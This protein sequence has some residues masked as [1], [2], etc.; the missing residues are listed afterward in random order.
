MDNLGKAIDVSV[1]ILSE[2]VWYFYVFP[3]FF[4]KVARE[5]DNELYLDLIYD[6][7]QGKRGDIEYDER[8]NK[9]VNAYSKEVEL[10][11][12]K[13]DIIFNLVDEKD[14]LAFFQEMMSLKNLNEFRALSIKKVL[15][16][17]EEAVTTN[18]SK[19]Q[20]LEKLNLKV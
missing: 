10:L 19:E 4:L 17:K 12:E 7:A 3:F 9:V 14:P 8:I 2:K 1:D 18:L 13:S 15:E 11:R 6:R 16:I 5:E 20:I